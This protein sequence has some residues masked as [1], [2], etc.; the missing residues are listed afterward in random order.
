MENLKRPATKKEIR[1]ENYR[2]LKLAAYRY[3]LTRS[4]L[5]YRSDSN[6]ADRAL[7]RAQIER[8]IGHLKVMEKGV[9]TLIETGE[10]VGYWEIDK[11]E[12][13]DQGDLNQITYS[14]MRMLRN[15]DG[16]RNVRTMTPGKDT[17]DWKFVVIDEV[18]TPKKLKEQVGISAKERERAE[19]YLGHKITPISQILLNRQNGLHPLTGEADG[20]KNL[21]KTRA[22]AKVPE[23]ESWGDIGKVVK[24]MRKAR[25]ETISNPAFQWINT[26]DP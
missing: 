9:R 8:T 13:V 3:R 18:L 23:L 7:E 14:V 22:N 15:Y 26:L 6:V 10:E 16:P 5:C 1:E 20:R 4:S 25:A 2:R 12:E 11:V 21:M 24:I 19:E 17:K